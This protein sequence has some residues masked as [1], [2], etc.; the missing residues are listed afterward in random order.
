MNFVTF[1]YL[2]KSKREKLVR[3]A[4][5]VN[6]LTLGGAKSDEV[7]DLLLVATWDADQ[8]LKRER[9]VRLM[10]AIDETSHYRSA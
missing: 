3:V 4:R 2:P 1:A 9:V 5:A 8:R 7:M 10:R 6:T